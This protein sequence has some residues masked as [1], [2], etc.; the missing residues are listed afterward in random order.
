MW[1]DISKAR[2][3]SRVWVFLRAGSVR[4]FASAVLGAVT[5]PVLLK[6]RVV[7]IGMGAIELSVV[8]ILSRITGRLVACQDPDS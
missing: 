2:T 3:P 1:C 4:T 5:A 8:M 7:L 6:G